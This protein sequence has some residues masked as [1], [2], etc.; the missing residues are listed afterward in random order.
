MMLIHAIANGWIGSKLRAYRDILR[1]A[2]AIR[3]QRREV[4]ALRRIGDR[5]IARHLTGTL[6]MG[7]VD[8]PA[9]RLANRFLEAYWSVFRR[10]IVW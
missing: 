4:Q 5:E 10:M 3:R 6:D 8:S 7:P 1:D 2:P 9:V